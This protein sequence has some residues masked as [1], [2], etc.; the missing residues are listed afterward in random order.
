MPRVCSIECLLI[1]FVR[2]SLKT[3]KARPKKT[4]WMIKLTNKK[5]KT[6]SSCIRT[7]RCFPQKWSKLDLGTRWGTIWGIEGLWMVFWLVRRLIPQY[8]ARTHFS[9]YQLAK[10]GLALKLCQTKTLDQQT[11]KDTLLTFFRCLVV[12][13][14]YDQ[15]QLAWVTKSLPRWNS[16]MRTSPSITVAMT[17][18][19]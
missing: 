5:W 9:R 3:R 19:S 1:K 13:L 15:A 8:G 18:S 2:I 14:I 16:S 10:K 12:N 6:L 4:C 17:N 7:F 11:V